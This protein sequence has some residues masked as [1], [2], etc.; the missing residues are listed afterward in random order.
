[1]SKY[2]KANYIE[3]A[4]FAIGV[5]AAS[6]LVGTVAARARR[7]KFAGRVVLITGGS[8]GFGLALARELANRQCRIALCAR[9]H[10]ELD[11]ARLALESA[12]HEVFTVP[13]DISHADEVTA[14]VEAVKRH[15]G[16]IDMLINNAGEIMVSPFANL[17]VA[18]FE[19]AMAVMFRGPLYTTLAV[20]PSMKKRGQGRIVNVTSIGGKVSVPHLLSYSCAK[21]AE[22]AFSN[23]LRNEVRQ[24]GIEVTTVIPG[25]MRTGS[26]VNA[27]FKGD[28]V[29]EAGW[30]GAAASLPLLSVSA[31]HAARLAVKAIAAGKTETVLGVPAQILSRAQ[32]LL[33]GLTA[34]LLRLGNQLLPRGGDGHSTST[35]RDLDNRHGS[36]YRL[37]TIL[38]KRAGQRLNQPV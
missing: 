13:C 9:D 6:A 35:G 23:G 3:S 31:E 1:M 29:A 26:H 25:L 32:N 7:R 16:K 4:A 14:M 37:L 5:A 38:G 30:F 21:A 34:E 36:L 17:E 10:D 11:R 20:L 15:Y 22:V 12:G 18:D 28:Q 8:R 33:P 2:D 24:F 27:A 19:R